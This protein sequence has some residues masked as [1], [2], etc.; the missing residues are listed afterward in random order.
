MDELRGNWV[1]H[2]SDDLASWCG[3]KYMYRSIMASRE[4]E[5]VNDSL[6]VLVEFLFLIV[7]YFVFLIIQLVTLLEN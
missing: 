5:S 6:L 4:N 7:E 2:E 1:N 3:F